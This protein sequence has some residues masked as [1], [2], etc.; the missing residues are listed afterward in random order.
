[1]ITMIIIIIII[2][3]IIARGT[4]VF[5]NNLLIKLSTIF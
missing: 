2:I 4:S 5:S 1:M 3:I